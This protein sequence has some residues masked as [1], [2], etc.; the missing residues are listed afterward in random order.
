VYALHDI[1][2]NT[3]EGVKINNVRQGFVFGLGADG[4]STGQQ[5]GPRNNTVLSPLFENVKQQ[6]IY[7]G[8]GVDNFFDNPKLADS[9]QNGGNVTFTQY[10]QV[11]FTNPGNNVTNASSNRPN[12]FATS[13]LSTPYLP[14]VAGRGQFTILAPR[15]VSL[16]N[17]TSNTLAFRLPLNTGADGTR[18]GSS[19]YTIEYLYQSNNNN[20]TR[21]G[22]MTVAVNLG[23][24]PSYNTNLQLSDE[25]DF[26]GVDTSDKSLQLVFSSQLLDQTGAAYTAAVGQIPSSLAILYRNTLAGD[27]G[28][29]SYSDTIIL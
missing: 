7:V 13:N 1:Y 26:A 29:L 25:Y 8:L 14:E 3:F 12:S 5:Y 2:A 19:I 23:S 17:V 16:A 27:N 28:Y 9:G 22:V 4:S 11:Y 6:A 20:F 21:K 24:S 18:G 10:P 15:R